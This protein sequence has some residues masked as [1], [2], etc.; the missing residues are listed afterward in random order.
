M[1]W[2]A[3]PGVEGRRSDA[4]RYGRKRR[5]SRAGRGRR[6]WG[7]YRGTAS[8]GGGAS[9]RWWSRRRPRWPTARRESG[10]TWARRPPWAP[11][12]PRSR[13]C[14]RCRGV[15]CRLPVLHGIRGIG[16]ICG[17][18]FFFLHGFRGFPD[19]VL[20]HWDGGRLL[21]GFSVRWGRQLR[22]A[23]LLHWGSARWAASSSASG[24]GESGGVQGLA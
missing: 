5:R 4:P 15:S 3:V 8:Y 18:G 14:L 7:S 23:T 19:L 11:R 6:L 17:G 16:D 9:A 24:S 10:R 12:L 1:R 21:H 20:V 2:G 22:L 13:R